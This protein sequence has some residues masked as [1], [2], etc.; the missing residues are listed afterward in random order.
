MP[1]KTK[2]EKIIAEYRRKLQQVGH[3]MQ[4]S[5]VTPSERPLPSKPQE[6]DTGLHFR[7]RQHHTSAPGVQ[8]A[9]TDMTELRSI[10][11]D[12][13]KTCILAGAAVAIEF[14]LYWKLRV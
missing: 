12:L 8:A 3:T 7:F 13:L 10:K 14:M 5:P 1:K 6:T 2:K 4:S 11:L 9:Q